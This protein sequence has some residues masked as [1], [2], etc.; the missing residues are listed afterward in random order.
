[1]FLLE[2]DRGRENL[3][4]I[5][6][7]H[8]EIVEGEYNANRSSHIYVPIFT[9]DALATDYISDLEHHFAEDIR[10]KNLSI[11]TMKGSD[12]VEWLK[13]N[14]DVHGLMFNPKEAILRC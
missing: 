1:M 10:N 5:P 8:A 6:H 9:D 7:Q 4:T 13:D 3:L 12:I 2:D 14:D 11:V